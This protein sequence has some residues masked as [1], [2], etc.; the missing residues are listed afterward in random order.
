MGSIA[1]ADGL[2]VAADRVM[3]LWSNNPMQKRQQ[4]STLIV[5]MRLLTNEAMSM[6][7]IPL[8]LILA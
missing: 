5:G 3:T 4:R 1:L 8:Q 7:Q 2:D 6:E